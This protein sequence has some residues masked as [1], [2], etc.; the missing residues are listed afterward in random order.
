MAA[1]PLRVLP[2]TAKKKY[3]RCNLHLP[4][5]VSPGNP[6]EPSDQF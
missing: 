5:H 6:P 1:L 3:G 2:A 4:C